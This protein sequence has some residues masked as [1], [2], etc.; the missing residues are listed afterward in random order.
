[1][2][3]LHIKSLKTLLVVYFVVSIILPLGSIFVSLANVNIMHML[4]SKVMLNTL[5]HSI[6]ASF[7]TTILTMAIALVSAWFLSR[8]K[9][10]HPKLWISLLTIP[11]LIPSIS[12]GIG[13]VVL[14]GSNGIF[15][16]L[17]HSNFHIYGLKGIVLGSF[18]YCFP[19]ALLMFLD[20]FQYEDGLVYSSA[21]VL[22]VPK[23]NQIKDI[24]LPYLRKPLIAIFFT[25]F[26]LTFTDYGVPLMVGGKYTTLPLYMYNEVIGLLD[27]QK[28]ALIGC[29]L[30]I[31]A[32]IAFLID[33][34]TQ[35]TKAMSF[36]INQYIVPVNKVR[37]IFSKVWVVILSIGLLLPIV[38]F[39]F[40]MVMTKYPV[41]L[42]FTFAHISRTLGM[43]MFKYLQNSV[44]IA[45]ITAIVGSAVAFIS[46]YFTSRYQGV[47]S[48]FVHLISLLTLAVPGIVLGLSYSLFFKGSIIQGTFVI[49]IMVNMV[50]FFA[51]PYLMACNA[52]NKLN[53]H[54]EDVASTLGISR[55]YL[56]K[57]VIIPLTKDTLIEMMSYMFINS[58]VTISA[59]AFLSTIAIQPLSLMITQLEGMM[60]IE[61]MAFISIVILAVNLLMKYVIQLF[62]KVLKSKEEKR[63]IYHMELTRREFDLLT[64]LEE[65]KDK[66]YTQREM[67]QACNVS[68]GTINHTLQVLN[69]KG[70][71]NDENKIT[72][73]G[74]QA[75]EPYRVKRAIFIA[76]GFG[77]RLVPLTINS[78]KP[79]IRVN[80][81]R[82]IDTLLD[83]VLA[84]GIEE[85]YIVRGYLKEQF[86]QLLYKYPMIQFIDNPYYNDANNIS[87][88]LCAR[89]YL[90]NAYVFEADLVL[91]NPNLIK[92]YQ[93]TSNY[94]GV[95]TEVTDDW[96]FETN[97][98]KQITKLAVGGRN[99]YHMFGVSYWT[100]ADG[101]KLNDDIKNVYELPGGKERYWDQVPLEYCKDHY[102]VEVRECLFEDIVEIDSYNDLKKIDPHYQ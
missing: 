12:H 70:Y 73:N 77:S 14:F 50:H 38:V 4:H 22:G 3:K 61:S 85:I 67:A 64:L 1:M 92:K 58:M 59:V 11:M 6:N 43:S 93:Y 39:I 26:T 34:F 88:M 45:L 42:T 46:A 35:D 10:K 89:N 2:N 20:A 82:M 40:L 99:V 13:L 47:I 16:N 7:I 48:K 91:Y 18:F 66:S 29:I 32:I 44:I 97:K 53:P 57:D 19:V 25:V 60:L 30:M 41:N 79:L 24:T 90:D 83:G 54:Y 102:K 98:N 55:F 81:T 72:N 62:K 71:I 8:S 33:I 80:G 101:D 36:H 63:G 78:P 56:L 28:G 76:A 94:L 96:C 68:L 87:S 69:E 100:K 75:L 5:M 49:L 9:L 65:N 51:S 21:N 95:K 37:D 84:A 74:I 15:T 86:D 52:F 27:F 31:P 23:L 17:F